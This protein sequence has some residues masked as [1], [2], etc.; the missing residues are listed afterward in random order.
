MRVSIIISIYKD[1]QSLE[2][3]LD[4]LAL[5]SYKKFEAVVV[6]DGTDKNIK[7]FIEEAQLKY[8][9][10]IKHTVQEDEGVRKARSQ[11]NGILKAEGE[12]LIFIDGDC[13][14][15]S[16]FIEGH[17]A[18]AKEN[19]ALSGR[20]INLDDNTS[21][22]LR[23]REIKFIEV[24]QKLLTKYLYLAFDKEVRYKQGIYVKPNGILHKLLNIRTRTSSILGCN[25]S[26]W[27]KDMVKLNGF[28]EIDYG[29]SAIPDDMDWT[30]RFK[31]VGI[32]IYSC[33][34]S[35]NIMHLWHKIHDR[36][37]ATKYLEKMKMNI[38]N[39]K[40]ICAG[41]LNLH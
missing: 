26:A 23:N 21:K 7:I 38:Q 34:N 27:K 22:K 9:F 20:R 5:Q 17:I 8:D 11:N 29:E 3:I 19:R 33:K 39:N 6:E 31:A 10:E 40:Y 30:W 12:Y 18:L 4:A 2:L 36:G 15:Y 24:E 41:G 16:T 1:I 32:E 14:P 28:N 25:F 35:A 13:I 37:D